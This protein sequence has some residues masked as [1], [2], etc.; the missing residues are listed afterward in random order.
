MILQEFGS[1]RMQRAQSSVKSREFRELKE[2]TAQTDENPIHCTV[3]EISVFIQFPEA[4]GVAVARCVDCS[5]STYIQRRACS[6][7]RR[8]LF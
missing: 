1:D 6:I 3:G 7:L 4:A 2:A 5:C 8:W